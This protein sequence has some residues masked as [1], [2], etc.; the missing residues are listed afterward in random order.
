MKGG[1]TNPFERPSFPHIAQN[2]RKKIWITR[3]NERALPFLI[4]EGPRN[5]L[6]LLLLLGVNLSRSG[7]VTIPCLLSAVLTH[8]VFCC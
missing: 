8:E 7:W 5:P 1:K 6:G 3:E 2:R 4:Q